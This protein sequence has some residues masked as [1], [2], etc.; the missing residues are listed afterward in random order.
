[1]WRLAIENLGLYMLETLLV[2]AL[3]LA[4]AWLWRN[5]EA[6]LRL[7]HWQLVLVVC[8]AL[9]FLGRWNTPVVTIDTDS[10]QITT[11][12]VAIPPPAGS[13]DVN[14]WKCLAIILLGGML[15]MLLRLIVGGLR[16]SYYRRHA[17]PARTPPIDVEVL[18]SHHV[19]GPV[20]YGIFR[21]VVLLPA[22]FESWPDHRR[23]CVLT[24]ELAHVQ[25]HDWVFGILEELIRSLL[26]FHP[27][28]WLVLNR[29]HLSREQV[30]DAEVLGLTGDR[31]AYLD[32]LLTVAGLK[33][34]LGFVPAPLFVRKRHLAM[35]VAHLVDEVRPMNRIRM[36]F[37][38]AGGALTLAGAGAMLTTLLPFQ[39]P[40]QEVR[41]PQKAVIDTSLRTGRQVV[42]EVSPKYPAEAKLRRIEGTVGIELSIDGKGLVSDAR[43]ISGPD[44]LRRAALQA[45]LQWQFAETGSPSRTTVELSFRL[46]KEA[47]APV[48][49]LRSIDLSAIPEGMRARVAGRIPLKE[50][51]PIPGDAMRDIQ[52][53]VADVDGRIRVLLTPDMVLQASM[54]PMTIRVG[55]NVQA[56][57]IRKQVRPIYPPEAKQ[58]R[59]QGTVRMLVTIDKEGR[60][61]DIQLESGHPI[62]APAAMDAV[63]QWEYEI[64]LLNGSPVE[65]KTAVDVNFTLAP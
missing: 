22:D 36:M 13:W 49:L 35:R 29:I 1:M 32:A 17:Q 44:E 52:A 65:V 9:P 12:A 20:S 55:G 11:R 46:P 57:K 23:H 50:G 28:V 61:T 41:Q 3:G 14:W 53:A 63:K 18:L 51:D 43:V 21:P 19:T 56:S 16:L 5:A 7:W 60:V 31:E 48:G 33:E 34:R 59:I 8:A 27:A 58:A 24:H 26:W 54:M 38:L 47:P 40:A 2:I 39:A 15:I 25:R 4:G 42:H 37:S 64:T 30:V 6:R 10:V 45:V 62:L